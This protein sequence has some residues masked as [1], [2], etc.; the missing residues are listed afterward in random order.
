MGGAAFI[1]PYDAGKDEPP[2]RRA[3]VRFRLLALLIVQAAWLVGLLILALRD[4]GDFPSVVG[5]SVCLLTSAGLAY[6]LSRS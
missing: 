4:E 1:G 3:S 6:L 2:K 5:L